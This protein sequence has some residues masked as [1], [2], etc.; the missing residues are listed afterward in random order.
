M[1]KRHL[2]LFA[3]IILAL[4]LMLSLSG[5][6]GEGDVFEGKCT[7]T[8]E[9]NGGTLDIKTSSVN[10]KIKYAYE[11]GTKILDVREI[12]GYTLSKSGYV[13]TGWYTSESCDPQ[14]RWN[15][16]TYINTDAVTLYA[17]WEKA[18]VYSYTIYYVDGGNE[19]SLGSYTVKAGD[20]FDDWRKYAQKRENFT[21]NGYY[22]D[23]DCTIAWDNSTTHPGGDVDLDI[24]V[25]ANYIPGKW[26]L[27]SD[28]NT[29]RSAISSNSNVY[30]TANVDFGG[31]E[32]SLGSY[33]GTFEGNGYTVS[34]FKVKKTSSLRQPACA[35]FSELSDGA[36]IKNVAFENVT[37]DLTGINLEVVTAVK[38]ALL[39]VEAKGT[40]SVESVSVSGTINTNYAGE[41][42]KA[43]SAFYNSESGEP[44][45]F[46]SSVTVVRD[47]T[48][49]SN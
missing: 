18:I 27:V 44:A 17:G 24:K 49:E 20:R 11:M 31:A 35:I 39:A 38:L 6:A 40:V 15:F 22:Q 30:L 42:P 19:Y 48:S 7:V 28:A 13:F 21:L 25:Y 36:V 37:Y 12:D 26:T 45:G 16:D 10:D 9:L 1:T 41:L 43:E 23:P 34:N 46:T 5:C 2:T 8:F 32:V 47:G 3:V 29:L 4:T 14:D 33:S